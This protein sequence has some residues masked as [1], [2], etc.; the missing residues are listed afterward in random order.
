MTSKKKQEDTQ[1]VYINHH[2]VYL[3][4]S[5]FELLYK[6]SQIRQFINN[7]NVLLS[8]GGQRFKIVV[9]AFLCEGLL[10]SLTFHW[11]LIGQKRLGISL[12][13]TF[14]RH[15]SNSW[16]LYPHGLSLYQRPHLTITSALAFNIWILVGASIQII[17]DLYE[18]YSLVISQ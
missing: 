9:L 5:L 3:K 17:T 4:Y 8:V 18:F 16:A 10:L 12:E 13:I 6:I 7:G 14:I 15:Y 2:S 1:H 11:I